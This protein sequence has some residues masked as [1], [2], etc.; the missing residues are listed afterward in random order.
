MELVDKQHR[1]LFGVLFGVFVL[2]GTSMTIIGA[3]LPRML[4]TFHWD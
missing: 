1:G 4:A 2:Y 3:T